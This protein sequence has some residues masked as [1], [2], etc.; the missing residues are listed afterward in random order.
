MGVGLGTDAMAIPWPVGGA[1][2]GVHLKGE[3]KDLAIQAS[4]GNCWPAK[5][6]SYLRKN[7]AMTAARP[8]STIALAIFEKCFSHAVALRAVSALASAS[9][10]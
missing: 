2:T 1:E 8:R 3:P 4:A 7:D 6:R 9:V 5:D 10:W